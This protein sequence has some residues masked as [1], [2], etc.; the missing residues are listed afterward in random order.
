MEYAITSV[1]SSQAD[2][3]KWL[4]WWR[5]HWRIENRSHYVRDVTLGEAVGR[6]RTGCAPENLA[7]ICNAVI[8]MLRR[9][10]HNNIAAALHENTL[11]L[12]HLFTKYHIV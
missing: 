6:I 8:G 7:S 3:A 12:P 11:Q 4:S 2:A 1:P 9:V 5:G 10:G